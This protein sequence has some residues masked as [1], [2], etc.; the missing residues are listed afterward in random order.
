MVL[1]LRNLSKADNT[2]G[3]SDAALNLFTA[4]RKHNMGLPEIPTDAEFEVDNLRSLHSI[5]KN[6]VPKKLT[7]TNVR[8]SINQNHLDKQQ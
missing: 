1:E 2:E 8:F 4:Y 3:H 5:H 7:D 6:T